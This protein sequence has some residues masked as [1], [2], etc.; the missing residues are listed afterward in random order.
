MNKK[1]KIGFEDSFA[2]LKDMSEKMQRRDISL[3]ES[4]EC[5][6]QGI[7]HYKECM[8]ILENAGQQ[9]EVFEGEIE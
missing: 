4:I 8:E 5:Y 1:E 9:I 2:M 3:E 6:S 7:R